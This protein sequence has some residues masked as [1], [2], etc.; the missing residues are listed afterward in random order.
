MIE[1]IEIVGAGPAGLVAAINLVQAGYRVTVYEEKL[2]VGHRFHGDFQ[3]LEN[4]SSSEDVIAILERFGIY[5]K[6]F[7]N[8]MCQPFNKL[9]VFDANLNKRVIQSTRP[10]FY[11]VQRGN[12]PGCLDYGLMEQALKAGVEIVFNKRVDK[13]EKGGIVAIGPRAADAIAKGIVFNT[14]MED[15]AAAILDDRLAPKGY[16]YLLIH[17]GEGTL[18]A[19]MFKDFKREREYFERTVEAF[20]KIF[21]SLDIMDPKEFGGY[22][23]CF[24]GMPVF[25][26][27]KYYVGEA[28]G[29]QDGLWGFGLRYAMTSGYL[30]A[31]A[32]IESKD[33]EGLLKVNLIPMQRASIVS[34][35]LFARLGNEGYP[36]LIN[37][38]T[39]GDTIEKLKRYYNPSFS[40]TILYPLASWSYKSRL[41]DKGCH[42]EDCTCVW[43]K[44]RKEV[45]HAR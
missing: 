31:R 25:E 30:A 29:L 34:R 39:R 9:T 33:Y 12:R 42:E 15:T 44:C 43:C 26:N 19:C 5:N 40:K 27:D 7:R 16:A 6:I 32:I 36:Y 20:K 10:F 24:M 4:W 11:L 21:P 38:L 8:Y 17:K 18:A 3:S 2:E 28:A 1:G 37:R 23:N 13:L 14:T 35:F 45:N 22:G 41:V